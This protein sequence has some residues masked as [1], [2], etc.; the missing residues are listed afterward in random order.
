MGFAFSKGFTP[1]Q[2]PDLTGKV[3]IVTG[4]NA[5][6]GFATIQHLVRRGAKIYM[7]ARSEERA[8]AAIRRLH[9]A[10]LGPGNG[11]VIWLDLDLN[12]PHKAKKA[13]ETF[14]SKEETLDVLI[15][16]ACLLMVPYTKTYYGVQDVVMVNYIGHFVFTQ[17]L[18]PILKRTAQQPNSDVRIVHVSSNGHDAIRHPVQF[19]SVEDF[20]PE[21][22]DSVFPFPSL[23]RYC[24]SKLPIVLYAKE[25]QRRLDAEGVPIIVT[26]LHPGTVNTDGAQKW[27][28]SLGA[29][30]SLVAALVINTF[31]SS[32]VVGAYANVFAAGAPEV[33]AEPRKYRGAYIVPPGRV[34]RSSEHANDERLAKELWDTTERFLE[35][36]GV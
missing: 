7:S 9:A 10:G 2:L 29:L 28:A 36:I 24:F 35:S 19:R 14:M 32:P 6:I 27:I 31:F 11:E 25:Q 18:L 3:M 15:N 26:S 1:A 33:R 16:C 20:N 5:G 34:G 17:T 13:A 12:D 8:K 22:K 21:Y 30:W 4:G 23:M